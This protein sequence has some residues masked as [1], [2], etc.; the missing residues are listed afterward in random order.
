MLDSEELSEDI[1]SLISSIGHLLEYGSLCSLE[2]IFE[3]LDK[4]KCKQSDYEDE[5]ILL[6]S[7]CYIAFINLVWY[8]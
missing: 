2:L 3:L 7:I 4:L 6:F 1:F 5:E 8:N